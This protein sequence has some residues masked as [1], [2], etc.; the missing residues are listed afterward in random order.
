MCMFM[1]TCVYMCVCVY[2]CVCVHVCILLFLRVYFCLYVCVYLCM[3]ICVW[4]RD[5][6]DMCVCT[7][8]WACVFVSVCVHVCV[9][10]CVRSIIYEVLNGNWFTSTPTSMLEKSYFSLFTP[11]FFDVTN[12]LPDAL[13]IIII[14]MI[15]RIEDEWKL[16]KLQHFWVRPEYWGRS[17]IFE[18]TCC[19]SNTSK[20]PS[21]NADVKNSHEV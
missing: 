19:H 6:V 20:R 16:S 8:V 17:L 10:V 18:E 12:I 3:C 2:V 21:A 4:I 1:C 15:M 14:I 7:N 5:C 13:I 11:S 9:Y